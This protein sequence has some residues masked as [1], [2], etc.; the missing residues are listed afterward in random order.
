MDL[1]L[2]TTGDGRLIEVQGSG[3]EATF[4]RAQ[5]DRLIDLGE[6]GIR[7]ITAAQKKALGTGWPF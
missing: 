2:V 1:N 4:S 5:L 6:S 7:A 3:E